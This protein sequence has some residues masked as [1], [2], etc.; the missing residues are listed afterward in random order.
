MISIKMNADVAAAV[1]M[2]ELGTDGGVVGVD[3]GELD[4]KVE[5][6]DE[7][8]LVSVVGVDE[9]VAVSAIERDA[10]AR[11]KSALLTPSHK[12]SN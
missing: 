11:S 4:G 12:M 9:G 6:L 3:E 7:G 2:L 10:I 8:E 5:G 1:A